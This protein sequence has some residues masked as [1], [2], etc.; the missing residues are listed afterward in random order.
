MP[1]P[2]VAIFISIVALAVLLWFV[3]AR[4]MPLR[5]FAWFCLLTAA[6]ITIELTV[7]KSLGERIKQ[8][9]TLS[10]LLELA[11]GSVFVAIFYWFAVYVYPGTR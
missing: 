1:R 10:V 7:A 3:L 2:R 4:H 5:Y 6:F 9:R 8:N 11:L